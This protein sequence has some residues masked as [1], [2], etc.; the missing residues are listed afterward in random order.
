M[1]GV[2]PGELCDRQL[3]GG[4]DGAYA[5]VVALGGRPAKVQHAGLL[6]RVER[7]AGVAFQ[8]QAGSLQNR[9]HGRANEVVGIHGVVGMPASKNRGQPVAA[10]PIE[11][12]FDHG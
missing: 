5:R 3:C 9:R 10:V 2:L 12:D 11:H 8:T 4:G 1:L 6:A 7:D